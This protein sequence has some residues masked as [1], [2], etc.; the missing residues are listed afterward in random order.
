MTVVYLS[1]VINEGQGS[2]RGKAGS[3]VIARKGGLAWS[4]KTIIIRN[5]PFTVWHPHD[6]QAAMRYLFGTVGKATKFATG[7]TSL[8]KDGH[9]V[10][11]G[12][13]VPKPA[14]IIQVFLKGNT[15]QYL[16]NFSPHTGR[17]AYHV[18]GLDML[19]TMLGDK[20]KD[21]P[22]ISVE[23]VLK[24]AQNAGVITDKEYSAIMTKRSEL[25]RAAAVAGR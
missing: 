13:T 17:P 10:P 14:A 16:K 22:S 20:A 6:R 15:D 11:A 1:S 4:S 12:T 5:V 21:L 2:A 8:P 19:K 7:T 23:E 24:A 3:L 25:V 9:K 18:H